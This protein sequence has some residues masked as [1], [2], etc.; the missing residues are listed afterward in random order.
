MKSNY[1][2]QFGAVLSTLLFLGA[3]QMSAQEVVMGYGTANNWVTTMPNIN[4]ATVT[5]IAVELGKVPSN[6]NF[7][8]VTGN[9]AALLDGASS[10]AQVG[11]TAN[12]SESTITKVLLHGSTNQNSSQLGAIIFSDKIPFDMNSI[13]GG[14][15]FT[16]DIRANA[17]IDN[18]ITAPAGTKSFRVYRR[19]YYW[20]STGVA[21]ESSGSSTGRTQFGDG[22]TIYISD[23]S[24]WIATA[25][26]TAPV[27]SPA[28]SVTA[29]QTLQMS[30][31]VAG[32]TWSVTNGTGTATIDAS[33]GLLSALTAGDV[34]VDY[35]VSGCPAAT[36]VTVTISTPPTAPTVTEATGGCGT[37]DIKW[38]DAGADSYLVSVQKCVTQLSADFVL[39]E[40]FASDFLN[41]MP[42]TSRSGNSNNAT[43]YTVDGVNTWPLEGTTTVPTP[44]NWFTIG[45]TNRLELITFDTPIPLVSNGVN[46]GKITFQIASNSNRDYSLIFNKGNTTQF[47]A[48]ELSDNVFAQI[49]N[50]PVAPRAQILTR[51]MDIPNSITS[52]SDFALQTN[53]SDSRFY[54][55]KIETWENELVTTCDDIA[56]SPFTVAGSTLSYEVTG[57]E[58]DTD[59]TVTVTA[60]RS[61]DG[62]EA[63]SEAATFTTKAAAECTNTPIISTN[64]L[65]VDMGNVEINTQGSATFTVT[66]LNLTEEITVTPTTVGATPGTL[67]Y[68]ASAETVTVTYTPSVTG[69]FSGTV[70]LESDGAIPVTVTV[71]GVCVLPTLTAPTNVTA[72]GG[73]GTA[74]VSWTAATGNP[75]SYDVQ[76]CS[77]EATSYDWTF[78]DVTSSTDANAYLVAAGWNLSGVSSVLETPIDGAI[79]LGSNGRIITPSVN[80]KDMVD[81]YIIFDVQMISDIAATYMAITPSGAL[82]T[83]T[84]NGFRLTAT[85]VSA[86]SVTNGS[87]SQ[88][89]QSDALNTG[90]WITVTI[91]LKNNGTAAAA[92]VGTNFTGTDYV[93]FRR[94]SGQSGSIAIKN[95]RVYDGGVASVCT[96]ENVGNVTSVNLSDVFGELDPET[97][98]TVTVTA[99]RN[100]DGAEVASTPAT[101]TTKAEEE[102]LSV[103]APLASYTIKWTTAQGTNTAM[104]YI[105][106]PVAGVND[107][108]GL[109]MFPKAPGT[110]TPDC[111]E[112]YFTWADVSNEAGYELYLDGTLLEYTTLLTG[113][114][115][116]YFCYGTLPGFQGLLQ[117]VLPASGSDK[118]GRKRSIGDTVNGG[119]VVAEYDLEIGT[120]PTGLDDVNAGKPVKDCF[121][122]TGVKVDCNTPGII[123][124]R[125]S[126]GSA[127]KELK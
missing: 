95:I 112:T 25:C 24:V 67:P 111:N 102:C 117:V 114:Y 61:S 92:Y 68:D 31:D 106:Q 17:C 5:E 41:P 113:A 2:K 90:G 93:Q 35:T 21:S 101:F 47:T 37:A 88:I 19:I 44:L 23:V 13:I 55:V 54:T 122:V 98:Y 42:G 46:R 6:Q 15:E 89:S 38:N 70:L 91:R 87:N 52:L 116:A 60:V 40:K 1:F 119:T 26:D 34:S 63:T 73:C 74:N 51:S 57:L 115:A 59:Y 77:S 28:G 72:E 69:A 94:D 39:S 107:N 36:P 96:T 62:A 97:D 123:I 9:P 75:T 80:I 103:I 110:D 7:C 82:P 125:F 66:G 32:G 29:G 99:I 109:V 22:Q 49:L 124:K 76:L 43:S 58:L 100:A 12:S 16:A 56:G 45:G 33:T 104:P 65:T 30:A 4:P 53:G 78:A 79:V 118:A 71:T 14:A 126:D 121:T 105:T 127:V 10:Y 50:T 48:T 11:L 84:N 27:I 86:S 120:V 8:A 83:A 64:T 20:E 3:A 108:K 81:P 85:A 18:T